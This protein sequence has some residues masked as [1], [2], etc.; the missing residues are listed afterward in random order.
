MCRTV[1]KQIYLE[2]EQ[3]KRLK[4]QARAL[5]VLSSAGREASEEDTR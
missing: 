3:E 1:R 5:S 2:P 4:H